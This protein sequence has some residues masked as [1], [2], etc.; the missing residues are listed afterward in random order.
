MAA[1][2][3]AGRSLLTGQAGQA[4]APAGAGP[5]RAP[6]NLR[7]VGLRLGGPENYQYYRHEGYARGFYLRRA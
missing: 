5:G 4:G 2:A 7:L 3:S 1:G 6:E